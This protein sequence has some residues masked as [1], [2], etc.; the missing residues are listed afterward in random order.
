MKKIYLFFL[1]IIPVL[2]F[3]QN[4]FQGNG[5][6]GFGGVIG[7]STLTITD[8]GTNINF[9]LDAG[10]ALTDVLVL[11]IDTGITG[12]NMIDANVEDNADGGRRAISNG[13]D[14][15]NGSVVTFPAGFEA[16]F[17][18]TVE[19]TFSGLFQ[20]PASGTVGD[21]GLSFINANNLVDNGNNNYT[22]TTT[23]ASLG[24]SPN[25]SFNFVGVYLNGSNAF[26]SDEGY[27][28]TANNGNI[29]GDDFSFDTVLTFDGTL[30]WREVKF[31]NRQTVT[32]LNDY[33]HFRG[34]EGEVSI[35]IFN[36]MAQRVKSFAAQTIIDDSKLYFSPNQSGIYFVRMSGPDIQ[37]TF[38]VMMD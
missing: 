7:N 34:I 9:S 17:A 29:A 14:Q 30:S 28:L 38:K 19:P 37:K 25:G 36:L 1:L 16:A 20:I 8:D 31:T 6:T 2:G 33:L 27:G 13:D 23:Y 5:N 10:A 21:N 22:F 18:I 35:D 3:S 4:V 12:R 15:G 26:T 11:Y 24:L 32:H